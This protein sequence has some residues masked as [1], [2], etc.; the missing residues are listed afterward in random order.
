[1]LGVIKT[2]TRTCVDVS[3]CN[4]CTCIVAQ[5]FTAVKISIVI[6]PWGMTM[7]ISST[8]YIVSLT[9]EPV[10]IYCYGKLSSYIIYIY[11]Q[12]IFP[13]NNQL[14]LAVEGWVIRAYFEPG[15]NSENVKSM[16]H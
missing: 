1:M 7:K 15:G 12:V 2:E 13:T 16:V 4:K 14:A 3:K 9:S 6:P 5:T 11:V 8:R 10:V